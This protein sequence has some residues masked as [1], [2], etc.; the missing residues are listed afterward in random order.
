MH[1]FLILKTV[2]AEKKAPTPAFGGVDA[3][4]H[5]PWRVLQATNQI[6]HNLGGNDFDQ[7]VTEHFIR[8]FR[9]KTGK[10][11]SGDERAVQKLRRE[12]ET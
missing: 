11:M 4:E 10:D 5:G 9:E 6:R 7:R 3:E 8:V 1:I 2:H 12:E